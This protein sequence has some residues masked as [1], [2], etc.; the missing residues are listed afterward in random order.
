MFE[1]IVFALSLAG[2]VFAAYTDFKERIVPNYLTYSLIVLGIAL[3]LVYSVL[4]NNF[5]FLTNSIFSTIVSFVFAYVLWKLGVWA[6]GDV[7]LFTAIS[8]LNPVNYFFLGG[9]MQFSFPQMLPIAIPVFFFNLF[10]FSLFA[11][12]PYSVLISVFALVKKPALV[13]EL[14][15]SLSDKAV[16]K[17]LYAIEVVLL[18]NFSQLVFGLLNSV[19]SLQG[20]ASGFVFLLSAFVIFFLAFR[21][22]KLRAIPEFFAFAYV[23]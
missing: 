12:F 20:I 3:H 6:G 2:L 8:A 10:V 14:K 1:L 18:L 19:L 4:Q 15:K 7:K 17:F 16:E 21:I 5:S 9:I 23:A 11:V 13:K 22:G